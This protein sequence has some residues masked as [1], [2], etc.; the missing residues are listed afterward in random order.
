M[1]SARSM[2]DQWNTLE[3]VSP[4]FV[5]PEAPN[6]PLEW[7][8]Q[9]EGVGKPTIRIRGRGKVDE[10]V[11]FEGPQSLCEIPQQH[12]INA[13]FYVVR[14]KAESNEMARPLHAPSSLS[15]M[16]P[17]PPGPFT[18][19]ATSR[20]TDGVWQGSDQ[21]SR[22]T[23]C[24]ALLRSRPWPNRCSTGWRICPL[25]MWAKSLRSS[26]LTVKETSEPT[27]A[28]SSQPSFDRPHGKRKKARCV[29]C[30]NSIQGK[31]KKV[32]ELCAHCGGKRQ[33]S[34]HALDVG[35]GGLSTIRGL[36]GIYNDFCLEGG[37]RRKRLRLAPQPEDVSR[38][39]PR[40][41]WLL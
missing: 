33:G 35:E 20:T 27:T 37:S 11:E 13:Q 12:D 14:S 15:S 6:R 2:A 36:G 23:S 21:T 8:M 19:R 24:Y 32:G 30:S 41:N 18:D 34:L 7:L 29:L 26:R 28:K 17:T 9:L 10:Q 39:L 3:I 25:S 22:R 4:F 38:C 31:M 1:L 5:G 40:K 16:E